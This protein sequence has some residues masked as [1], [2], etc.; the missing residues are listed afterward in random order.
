[1]RRSP[2]QIRPPAPTDSKGLCPLNYCPI[3]FICLAILSAGIAAAFLWGI[4]NFGKNAKPT[5]ATV[6]GMQ[7]KRALVTFRHDKRVVT[8]PA[9]S[10]DGAAVSTGQ[11]LPIKYLIN[12][13]APT[14]WDVRIIGKA[15]YGQKKIK[16]L[17][18]GC[19]F[20]S[21]GFVA[22]AIIAGFIK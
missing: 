11:K 3:I 21:M 13:R 10:F 6:I 17:A 1:M 19:G 14:K 4:H 16:R 5:V 2:V 15:G 9:A 12:D 22:L 7:G 18:V 8:A 20:V